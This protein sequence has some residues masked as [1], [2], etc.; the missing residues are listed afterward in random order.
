MFNESKRLSFGAMSKIPSFEVM[1]TLSVSMEFSTPANLIKPLTFSVTNSS[2]RT[3]D[4]VNGSTLI[5][6][7]STDFPSLD[8]VLVKTCSFLLIMNGSLL[9]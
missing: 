8:L 9:S 1:A 6:S 2:F 3:I 5:R 7:G 4:E